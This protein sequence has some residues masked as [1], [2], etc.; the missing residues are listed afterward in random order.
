MPTAKKTTRTQAVDSLIEGLLPLVWYSKGIL[1]ELC[2]RSRA[3]RFPDEAFDPDDMGMFFEEG[4]EQSKETHQLF[5]EVS[6]F[7][8]KLGPVF[9]LIG[10]GAGNLMAVGIRQAGVTQ[11]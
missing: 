6:K 2:A 7:I 1:A 4:Y 5:K 9:E 10:A 11:Q 8:E 3:K